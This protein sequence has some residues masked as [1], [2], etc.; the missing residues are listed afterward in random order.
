MII[1]RKD[2]EQNFP[3]QKI[4]ITKT[5]ISVKLNLKLYTL[6]TSFVGVFSFKPNKKN[7]P[8]LEWF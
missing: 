2:P 6:K 1:L 5:L 3:E 7:H 8:V 4:D